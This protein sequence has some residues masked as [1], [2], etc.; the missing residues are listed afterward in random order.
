M[1]RAFAAAVCGFVSVLL[2]ALASPAASA[3]PPTGCPP[4]P[5]PWSE[6]S[7]VTTPEE[8]WMATSLYSFLFVE[9]DIGEIAIE[10]FGFE[11]EEE[12]YF[13]LVDEFEARA[14]RNQ[15]DT[16]CVWWSGGDSPG[17]PDW[18][19]FFIENNAH[20]E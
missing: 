7:Y 18:V 8:D 2:V 20:P 3:E 15:D 12:L 13:V 14:D 1:P 17:L 6:I 10:E 19:F 11:S 4:G 16:I 5:T 9:T